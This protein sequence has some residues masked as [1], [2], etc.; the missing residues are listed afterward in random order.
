DYSGNPY[1]AYFS[2]PELMFPAEPLPERDGLELKDAV[3]GVWAGGAARAYP[4]KEFSSA[5]DVTTID[6]ELAGKTFR[7]RFD[8]EHQTLR[9][10]DRDDGVNHAY[11]LWFAWY[12]FRP[13]TEVFEYAPAD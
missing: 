5:A 9:V 7:I 13:E 6:E 8:P 12:A 2:A 4:L 3:V 10:L 1:E 11:S